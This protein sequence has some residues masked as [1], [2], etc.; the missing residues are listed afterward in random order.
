MILL[1]SKNHELECYYVVLL[2][3]EKNRIYF[4]RESKAALLITKL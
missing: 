1:S 2:K 3:P 4:H